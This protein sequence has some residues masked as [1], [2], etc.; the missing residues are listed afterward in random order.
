MSIRGTNF[1]KFRITAIFVCTAAGTSNR[2]VILAHS[3]AETLDMEH[4]STYSVIRCKN[5]WISNSVM[6]L[7]LNWLFPV[8][9][10]SRP[11]MLIVDSATPHI[12]N[13]TKELLRSR[14]VFLHVIPGGLTPLLQPAAVCHFLA[15]VS[16]EADNRFMAVFIPFTE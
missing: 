12:S 11:S 8:L 3:T 5:A 10:S 4:H 14:N 16:C 13:S 2:P 9:T 6:Q 1:E 7:F 15:E